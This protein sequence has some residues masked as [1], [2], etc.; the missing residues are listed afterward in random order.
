MPRMQAS[1][2]ESLRD[3]VLPAEV[4]ELPSDLAQIDELL[5]DP[6]PLEPLAAHWRRE[7]AERGHDSA[8]RGRPTIAIATYLRLMHPSC[9]RQGDPRAPLRPPGSG[10]PSASGPR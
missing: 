9:D 7:T 8:D 1:Q 4:R 6:K 10:L 3:E 5:G 2:A